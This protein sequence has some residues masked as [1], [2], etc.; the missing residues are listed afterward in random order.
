MKK[1]INKKIK[2]YLPIM[3]RIVEI[4]KNNNFKA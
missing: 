4:F 3:I 1:N 2:K